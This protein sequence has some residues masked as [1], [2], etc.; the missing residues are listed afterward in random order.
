[1]VWDC[2]QGSE[3]ALQEI[4][5]QAKYNIDAIIQPNNNYPFYYFTNTQDI[6]MYS[7]LFACAPSEKTLL[8]MFSDKL[9]V[10]A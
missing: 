9:L 6:R 2:G 4:Y 5:M 10:I 7:R 8:D 3:R 1:M